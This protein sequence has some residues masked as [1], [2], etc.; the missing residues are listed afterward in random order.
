MEECITILL[1]GQE[2]AV[3]D[4]SNIRELFRRALAIWP[5]EAEGAQ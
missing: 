4:W 1:A 2:I 3:A 5:K